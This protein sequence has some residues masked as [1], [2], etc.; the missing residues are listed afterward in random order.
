[1]IASPAFLAT[2]LFIM[3]QSNNL[4]VKIVLLSMSVSHSFA[5]AALSGGKKLNRMCIS[6]DGEPR[7]KESL[8]NTSNMIFIVLFKRDI[9]RYRINT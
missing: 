1:M 5:G 4:Q 9:L 7:Q 8:T 3:E 6:S 2:I